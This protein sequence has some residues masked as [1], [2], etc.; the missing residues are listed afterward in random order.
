MEILDSSIKG[1]I[2]KSK[3][4]NII[5]ENQSILKIKL[6]KI[7]LRTYLQKTNTIWYQF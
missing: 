3:L 2:I 5:I 6:T 4:I 1:V 7:K